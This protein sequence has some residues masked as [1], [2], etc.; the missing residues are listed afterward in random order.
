MPLKWTTL[1]SSAQISQHC[2]RTF[3]DVC[4]LIASGLVVQPLMCAS[5]STKVSHG[6]HQTPMLLHSLNRAASKRLTVLHVVAS[7]I[8][9]R[10]ALRIM[11]LNFKT[12]QIQTSPGAGFLL[13][14]CARCSHA[15]RSTQVAHPKALKIQVIIGSMLILTTSL[16]PRNTHSS[17]EKPVVG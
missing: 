10:H 14:R 12:F 6:L 5:S 2:S 11:T 8:R 7:K 16:T 17:G 4:F 9:L 1:C 13:H 15:F 3:L